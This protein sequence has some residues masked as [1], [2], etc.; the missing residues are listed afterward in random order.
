[1]T[2][3]RGDFNGHFFD[4]RAC[5]I[6]KEGTKVLLSKEVDGSRTLNGGAVKIGESS[7]EAV[8]REF[9]EETNLF[10]KVEVLLGVI[11]NFFFLKGKPYQQL[12]FVYEVSLDDTKEQVLRGHEKPDVTWEEIESVTNLKPAVLN[13]W[14]VSDSLLPLHV[15]NR[16]DQFGESLSVVE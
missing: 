16:E 1:M 9:Y 15:V 12:M 4:V 13:E 7:E 3:I 10:V 6:L 14:L 2:D 8:V 11:E 5:G